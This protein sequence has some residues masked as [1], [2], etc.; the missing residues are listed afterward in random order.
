MIREKWSL[1]I[2]FLAKMYSLVD[3]NYGDKSE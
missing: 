3:D 1:L 2:V